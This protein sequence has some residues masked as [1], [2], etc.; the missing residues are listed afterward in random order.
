MPPYLA[1]FETASG[2]LVGNAFLKYDRQ[3]ILSQAFPAW[4]TCI[5]ETSEDRRGDFKRPGTLYG[6]RGS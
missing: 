2:W 4:P 1:R 6:V 3:L 5:H